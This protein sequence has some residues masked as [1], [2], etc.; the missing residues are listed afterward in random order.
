MKYRSSLIR[1]LPTTF[2]LVSIFISVYLTIKS[3]WNWN[4]LLW[5]QVYEGFNE[6][7]LFGDP[8]DFEWISYA[9]HV[10]IM[11]V[12][13]LYTTK[14]KPFRELRWKTVLFFQMLIGIISSYAWLATVPV[15][16]SLI[17]FLESRVQAIQESPLPLVL[18][19][20]NPDNLMTAIAFLPSVG[21]FLIVLWMLGIYLRYADE[22]KES[23]EAFEW[24]S[25]RLQ[26]FSRLQE[27][28]SDPDIELGRDS[29]TKEY[30][31][32]YGK[33]RTLNNLIIGSIGSGKTSALALPIINQDL[34]WM[35]R[36]INDFPNIYQEE[37]YHTHIKQKYLNGITI[38]EPSNDL[39]QKALKLVK[40]HKIPEKAVYYIDPTNPNTPSINPMKGPVDKVAEAFAMVMEGLSESSQ[41]NFF[42]EQ[43]QR[44]HLKQ[45]IYLL[46][47][48]DPDKQVTFDDLI[49]MYNNPQLVYRMHQKLKKRIPENID[50]IKDRDTRNEAKILR[51]VDEWF[52][53]NL[54]PK[55]FRTPQGEF[56]EYV[57]EGPYRGDPVVM[58]AQTEYVRGLRNILNDISSNILMRR[59]IFGESDFDFDRHLEFGG[60][61]LVNT[62]K[63]ELAGLSNILGKIVLL[64]LQ[65]AVFRRPPNVST[66][67]HILIDEFPDYI[68]QPFKEFP[69]QSRKYKVILTVIAQT[70]AQLADKYGEKYMETLLGTLRH[71]MV[72]ADIPNYDAQIFSSIFGETQRYE[73]GE[74]ESSVSPTQDSPM[75]RAGFNYKKTKE[76][77]LSNS[78]LIYQKA[79]QCAVKLV[80]HNRPVP[81]RQ[82]DANFVSE[83]EYERAKFTVKNE[84]GMYWWEEQIRTQLTIPSESIDATEE[85]EEL[86]E[87]TSEESSEPPRREPVGAKNGFHTE[88][89]T[90]PEVER[91]P[92]QQAEERA[93]STPVLQTQPRQEYVYIRKPKRGASHV[94]V[95]V[96]KNQSTEGVEELANAAGTGTERKSAEPFVESLKGKQREGTSKVGSGEGQ[97]AATQEE[98]QPSK[99][100]ETSSKSNGASDPSDVDSRSQTV[101][102]SEPNPEVLDL[103]KKVMD[104]TPSDTEE[105]NSESDYL[106]MLE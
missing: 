34:H 41:S 85:F 75:T 71:K 76:A 9:V 3:L 87:E 100:H 56:T 74:S 62:A 57:K 78:D 90:I 101:I 17:P 102:V 66:Y 52:D 81:A 61:L 4:L 1:Q 35:T 69:A 46:K 40:A 22:I 60:V 58:D 63:G 92:S 5:G 96:Q 50:L 25:L 42:F 89:T 48:H 83:E 77:V 23:F 97:Q 24:S 39:C 68:Y 72:F 99:Y 91:P 31:I 104:A 55:T 98:T 53:L 2:S 88:Q 103:K 45:Y 27:E 73:E 93:M 18:F 16:Q 12:T 7:T 80:V 79:F 38:I 70:L 10:V 19:I 21:V 36:F 26:H 43:S 84:S 105:R 86:E 47:L 11:I 51:G 82:I 28:V 64:S 20:G 33:D 67:H 65:N 95:S 14:V 29:K 54:I 32:Q 37:Q 94:P 6:W 8:L 44:N 106:T 15:I 59:V 30:V 49:D 13:W